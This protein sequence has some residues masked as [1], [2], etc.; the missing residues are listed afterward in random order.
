MGERRLLLIEQVLHLPDP[1]LDLF[2]VVSL[3]ESAKIAAERRDRFTVVV[4]KSMRLS[5]VEK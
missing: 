5:D 1:R 4:R 2:T 3:R